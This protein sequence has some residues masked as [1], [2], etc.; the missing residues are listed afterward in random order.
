MDKET[1]ESIEEENYS[2][3]SIAPKNP[4]VALANDLANESMT[5][6]NLDFAVNEIVWT[7][8]RGFATWPARI[9]RIITTPA[10][11]TMYEIYWF[12]DYRRS[13]VFRLQV[14]KFLENFEKFA[15]KFDEVVDLKTAFEAMY[16]YRQKFSGNNI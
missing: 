8:V 13:K 4:T 3:K 2:T 11:R 6:A 5:V 14:F 7:K 9:E 10:G 12:S 16:T 1:H 15:M